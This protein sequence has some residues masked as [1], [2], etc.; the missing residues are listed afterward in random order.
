VDPHF[1]RRLHGL[2]DRASGHIDPPICPQCGWV[3]MPHLVHVDD[4]EVE[5]L[6]EV[7]LQLQ[8]VISSLDNLSYRLRAVEHVLQLHAK[9]GAKG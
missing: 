7:S 9:P 2:R 4:I 6:R 5:T 8:L 3:L 1:E